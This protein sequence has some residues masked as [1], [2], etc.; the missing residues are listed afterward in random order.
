[1]LAGA[2]LVI[3]MFHPVNVSSVTSAT[4]VNVHCGYCP[5]LLWAVRPGGSL[6]QVEE[7]GWLGLPASL[8]FGAWMT[9][10][11]GFSFVEATFIL[12]RLA[13]P[14]ARCFRQASWDV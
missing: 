7:T 9:L 12:P 10:V 4:W 11:C 13:D 14:A 3:G 1:M 2:S 8:L 6:R 5:G